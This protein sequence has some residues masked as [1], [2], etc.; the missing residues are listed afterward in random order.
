MSLREPSVFGFGVL[1]MTTT[2]RGAHGLP[3]ALC[4]CPAS[5]SA[6]DYVEIESDRLIQRREPVFLCEAHKRP[7]KLFRLDGST[8]DLSEIRRAMWQKKEKAD[9]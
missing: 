8:K 2:S 4:G 5:Y 7:E 6:Y 3:C 9:A 1:T